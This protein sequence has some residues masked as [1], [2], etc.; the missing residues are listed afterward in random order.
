MKKKIKLKK[1]T[2]KKL[3]LKL[4]PSSDRKVA[5]LF[6]LSDGDYWDPSRGQGGAGCT[7][8]VC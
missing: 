2:I 7:N 3:Q 8:G 1:K 5:P 6:A 4:K